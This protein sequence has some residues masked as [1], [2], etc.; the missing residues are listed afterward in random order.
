M[1]SGKILGVC[2]VESACPIHLS[3][4]HYFSKCLFIFEREREHMCTGE[5]QKERETEDPKKPC[6]VSAE[7]NV[8]LEL[9]NNCEPMT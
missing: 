4:D 3:Y 7:P 2:P 8:G 1:I 6:S 9:M 5:G